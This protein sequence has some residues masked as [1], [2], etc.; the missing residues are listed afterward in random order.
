LEDLM[1]RRRI[2]ADDRTKWRENKRHQRHPTTHYSVAP[3]TPGTYV[4]DLDD[5]LATGQRFGCIL[6]DPPW[7][8]DDDRPR[9]DMRKH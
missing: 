1:G 6:A 3:Q 2:H 4:T 8:F 7:P 9:V 5:L